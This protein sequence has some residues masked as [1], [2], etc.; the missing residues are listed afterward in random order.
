MSLSEGLLI[1]PSCPAT[2]RYTTNNGS[3]PY[4]TVRWG[5]GLALYINEN[6]TYKPLKREEIW[7]PI[8]TNLTRTSDA[9]QAKMIRSNT[10]RR[11]WVD[12]RL[13]IYF[14]G[15]RR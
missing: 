15:A 1:R 9:L 11:H 13:Y 10:R 14:I 4:S 12:R 3:C 8:P 7:T 6:R 2:D 5:A